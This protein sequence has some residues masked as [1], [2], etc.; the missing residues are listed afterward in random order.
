MNSQNIKP[1]KQKEEKQIQA[2]SN[3][4]NIKSKIILKNI[5]AY[6]KIRKSLE[7]IKC[8]KKLQNRLNITMHDYISYSDIII[9][10]LPSKNKFGNFINIDESSKKYFHIYF[11]DNENESN[12]S[13]IAEKD[14]VSKIK[15]VIEKQITSFEK[16]FYNF[17][18]IESISFK[19]F[20]RKNIIN[21]SYMFSGCSALKELD[22]SNFNTDKVT[23]MNNMFRCC[24]SLKE[25]DISNFNTYNLIDMNHIFSWC[26]SLEKLNIKNI[27]TKNVINMKNMFF[28]KRIKSF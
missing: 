6:L 13:Y 21:M 10:L 16:L 7:I 8:S 26:I 2:K 9:E 23:D 4:E 11:N 12:K 5:F 28:I 18:C 15:I 22:L 20:N 27:E 17:G 24:G 14:K 25:L 1:E 19:Q 3:F